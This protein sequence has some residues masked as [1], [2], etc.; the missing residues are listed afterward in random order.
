MHRLILNTPSKLEVDHVDG[1][2]LNNQR[3]NIRN[4]TRRENAQNRKEH[5]AN[6]ISL[7]TKKMESG[8]YQSQIWI[9]GV[10]KYLGVYDTQTDA[11]KAFKTAEEKHYG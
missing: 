2:G 3:Y 1:N 10:C 11:Y 5:R 9:K 7:G 4:A 8:K 6:P